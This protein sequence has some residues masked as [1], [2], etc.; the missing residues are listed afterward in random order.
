MPDGPSPYRQFMRM[1]AW[2]R[3]VL[4]MPINRLS[5]YFPTAW[6]DNTLAELSE[7]LG[8]SGVDVAR[9]L[10]FLDTGCFEGS[11]LDQIRAQ[12]PWQA[13]G[14][15]PNDNAV[16]AARAKGHTVWHGYA[17]DALR[18][19]P[20]GTQF[21]VV[22]MGQSIEHVD[23][24][25]LVLRRLRMLLAPGGVLVMSTPSLDSRQIDWYGPTWAHWHPPYH[26]YIF[27]L[28]ALRALGEQAGL[29]ALCTRTY[30]H[31]YWTAVT[32]AQNWLGL[33]GAASHAV[34]FDS[35]I[36]LRAQRI[37]IFCKLFWN[38][39]GKGDYAFVVLGDR[40]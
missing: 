36:V 19:V 20:E 30:T 1:P 12:L 3:F 22:F 24:P 7:V 5:R 21:D 11:L 8:R 35:G 34:N 27:S 4:R 26:R 2:E 29:R 39:L 37:D 10:R 13:S 18:L 9:P 6:A 16:A 33:G 25:V 28:R 31:P 15:E 38:R 40:A 14:L 23:D 17:H 32:V